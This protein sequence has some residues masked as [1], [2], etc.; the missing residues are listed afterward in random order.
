MNKSRRLLNLFE[1]V[2]GK[3][4]TSGNE[5][6]F[7]C[8]YC[9]HHKKKLVINIIT[10]K[11]HCW[12]CGVKG[13]GAER[14]FRQ[15]GSHGR[16]KELHMLT[17]VKRKVDN[18]KEVE[19]VSLPLEFKPMVDGNANNPEFRNAAKYLKSRGVTKTDVLRYNI[20]YCDSGQYK[21]MVVI[22]S[23]DSFGILNYFVGRAYYES[24]FKHKNPKTSKDVVGFE[25]LI[26]WNEDI[27][28]C[29]GVFDAIA[30]GE[31]SI[32]IFGKFLPKSLRSKLRQNKVKRVNIVL[33]SDAKSESIKLCE[34]LQSE[35]IDVRIIEMQDDEDPSTLGHDKITEL[36][37]NSK[38]VDFAKLLEMKFGL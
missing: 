24:D 25:L 3:S 14:I 34:Y 2:L 32:P 21:G 12:V 10:Q 4:M 26:N 18:S 5:A 30:L 27:N 7:T 37:N 22:P 6:T 35:N 13:V 28:I 20:G 36:I 8:P 9:N 17:G 15:V 38:P 31:N 23:Y 16:V 33:D 1:N 29:E 19:H 11:W